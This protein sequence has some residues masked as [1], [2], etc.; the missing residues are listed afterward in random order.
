MKKFKF[1]LIPIVF[2]FLFINIFNI[3]INKKYKELVESKDLT[4]L[5]HSYNEII[6]DRGGVLKDQMHKENDLMILG[7][8]EL[9][10]PVDQLPTNI[11]P[12]S[13]AEY[14]VSI[15]GRAYTQSLQHATIIS[16]IQDISADD[17]IAIIISSQW[18]NDEPGIKSEDF[19]V[20]FSEKQFYDFFNNE[21]IKK[22]NKI[23]YAKR[24][25]DLLRSSGEYNEERVYA[26]LYYRD[27]LISKIG[28]TFLS[29]YY[30]FKNYMLDIKDKVQSIK[31][32]KNLSNK[33]QKNIKEINW[34]NEYKKAE[35]EGKSKVTN[36]DIYVDD[37]Y[38]DN[39]L[40][41]VYDSLKNR[42]E[43]INLLKSKE[44]DDYKFLL[45]IC[46]DNN[47]K[48]LIILMPVNG[49]YYDYLGFSKEKRTEFYDTL[50]II[51]K[52]YDFE[53]LNLQNKEYEKYYMYDVM[54]LGW[55]GWLN[56]N[57]EMYKYFNER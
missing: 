10:S 5:K 25:S 28:L 27:N 47:I 6:R 40:R 35:D 46:K 38:Y 23:Y 2:I 36:N 22:E 31:L 51:A 18:F 11:F 17:K 7:S 34:E 54:H 29:P 1:F 48:P 20:N 15:Y 57:E 26:N 4:S 52:E 33:S 19:L 45:E 55:K 50:E 41:N 14:D 30:K 24:I 49:F 37:D 21:K 43:N 3:A 9:A 32:L 8:S 56:I 16:N 39:N 44:L 53:T 42:L 12:F 13:G